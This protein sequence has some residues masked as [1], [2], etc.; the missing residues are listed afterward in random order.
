MA[1]LHLK[2]NDWDDS[3]A[4][5]DLGGTTDAANNHLKPS[6][7][8]E[9]VF[10]AVDF[11]V[12]GKTGKEAFALDLADVETGETVIL[13]FNNVRASSGKTKH[14]AV[15]QNSKFGK[16]YRECFGEV[17]KARF[18]KSEQ[19][20]KH[21][22]RKQLHLICETE[23][24]THANGEHYKKVTSCRARHPI[25]QNHFGNKLEMNRKQTGNELETNWKRQSSSK[26]HKHLSHNPIKSTDKCLMTT[27]LLSNEH[28][29]SITREIRN[30][31]QRKNGFGGFDFKQMPNETTEQL[32]DRVLDA[33]WN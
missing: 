31:H 7:G 3:D 2:N 14:F 25:S 10:I 23:T 6:Q 32:Y 19:L 15:S 16:L 21:F 8:T 13:F 5:D 33:T 29:Q 22:I 11:R 24:A 12:I 4:F 28:S 20:V 26:P 1:I 27:E 17:K 9:S 18:A 30:H